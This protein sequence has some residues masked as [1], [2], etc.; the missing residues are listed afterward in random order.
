GSSRSATY[1]ITQYTDGR[2]DVPSGAL[3]PS[4]PALHEDVDYPLADMPHC[5]SVPSDEPFG[6]LLHE[7][8]LL[9]GEGIRLPGDPAALC[10]LGPDGFDRTLGAGALAFKRGACADAAVHHGA[11]FG[12]PCAQLEAGE[13]TD[14]CFETVRDWARSAGV[15]T[16]AMPYCPIGYVADR[17][18]PVARR[19]EADAG[20]VVIPQLRDWDAGFWPHATR[21]FF[22]LK[23][24]IPNVL[25]DVGLL[26]VA[27]LPPSRQPGRSKKR[28][29]AA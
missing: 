10:V 27:S 9:G 6:L 4:A 29:K 1:P 21:G 19:L 25:A 20:I 2:F 24:Q 28:R 3:A 11:D 14:A 13:T 8:D 22:K 5:P 12:L 15:E 7:D 26:D 23:E 17:L 16:I 18:D